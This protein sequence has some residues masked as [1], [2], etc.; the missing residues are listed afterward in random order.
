MGLMAVN[1]RPA[2]M[3]RQYGSAGDRT[4][5]TGRI[6]EAERVPHVWGS[7][8]QR[9]SSDW[10]IVGCSPREAPKA[11]AH[12]NSLGETMQS[13]APTMECEDSTRHGRRGPILGM[14]FC[15]NCSHSLLYFDVLAAPAEL[16]ALRGS[17]PGLRAWWEG[18]GSRDVRS[19]SISATS[20][21]L[22]PN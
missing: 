6:L 15:L 4:A 8:T 22:T 13:R 1:V 9:F 20:Q 11:H 12:V 21:A 14:A 18:G 5:E 2:P 3:R 17:L 7:M 10:R 19:G 16:L